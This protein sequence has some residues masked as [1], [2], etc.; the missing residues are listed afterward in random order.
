MTRK[1]AYSS[2]MTQ[3][4]GP[5]I[6]VAH[7]AHVYGDLIGAFDAAGYVAEVADLGAGCV[8]IYVALDTE[9]CQYLTIAGQACCLP[10]DRSALTGWTVQ[11]YDNCKGTQEQATHQHPASDGTALVEHLRG[12][13][14]I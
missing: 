3:T 10:A 4:P 1:G 11:E 8:V 9:D 5:P 14:V 2:A 6:T 13:N 12:L 7:A